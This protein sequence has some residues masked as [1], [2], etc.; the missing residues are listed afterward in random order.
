MD[1][2]VF[3]LAVD[4]NGHLYAGGDFYSAGGAAVNNIAK[5]EG[6]NWL[7]LGS[8]VDTTVWALAVSGN[9]LYVGGDFITAGGLVVR[10]IAK[11]DGSA[12]SGLGPG[13]GGCVDAF[14]VSGPNLYVG[15][16]FPC[17]GDGQILLGHVA[18]W[19]GTSWSAL[20]YGV[21]G[22]VFALALSGT[23][24][25]IGGQFTEEYYLGANYIIKWDGS[26]W[27]TMGSGTNSTVEA[28][29]ISG[30]DL[31]V[32]GGFTAAGGKPSA[33]LAQWRAPA[34]V[35]VTGVTPSGGPTGGGQS[36]T[37]TGTGFATS[38]TIVVTLGG[39]EAT[40]VTP[41]I[42]TQLTCTTPPHALGAVD[43][44]VT[45][46]DGWQGTG[47]GAYTYTDVGPP[48]FTTPPS[49]SPSPG[50]VNRNIALTCGV[51]GAAPIS[52]EWTFGDGTTG[53]GTSANHI[54]RR[55]KVYQI[56]AKATDTYGQTTEVQLTPDLIV[57]SAF[58]QFDP[59]SY[60][61]IAWWDP[62]DG[63]VRMWLMEATT[64]RWETDPYAEDVARSVVGTGDLNRDGKTD[65]ILWY[66]SGGGVYARM[67]DGT[68]PGVLYRIGGASPTLYRVTG[69]TDVD[70]DGCADVLFRRVT[71]GVVYAWLLNP[72]SP[73][74]VRSIVRI[75]SARVAGWDCSTG[76]GDMNKDGQCDILWRELPAPN[77]AYVWLMAPGGP[78]VAS[79]VGMAPE[80]AN[81]T[82]RGA[83]DYDSDGVCDILWRD[84]AAGQ[85]KIWKMDGT[86]KVN[87]IPLPAG[88]PGAV[89][90]PK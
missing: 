55:P 36:V 63:N 34:P 30:S 45:N 81:W 71:D 52:V 14:A 80:A 19:D 10:R 47:I 50:V 68:T 48:Q 33:G 7:P 25:Y 21:D 31:L 58:A 40:A 4:G 38:G 60:M 89:V 13:L 27:S 70:G 72:G 5:W 2:H 67:M 43:V 65:L 84:P 57:R 73:P 23:D 49:A 18:K 78:G 85:N 44:V 82:L 11:W 32:G 28:L 24:L 15:G 77:R 88:G 41:G 54:Y 29:Q 74:T 90:G 79:L 35:T 16:F 37:I 83:G 56:T 42:S 87:D 46:P 75:G 22:Q 8:G 59:D 51:S 76:A 61:D 86:S 3:A 64:Q 12:W 62:A 69:G 66:G 53:T 9:L 26:G 1:Y 6:S 17:T 39:V 20:Q